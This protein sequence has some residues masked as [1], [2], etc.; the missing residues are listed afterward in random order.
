M[1]VLKTWIINS[2]TENICADLANFHMPEGFVFQENQ[3]FVFIGEF[4]YLLSD[5]RRAIP[6]PST[7]APCKMSAK[8][9]FSY[10]LP[11]KMEAVAPSPNISFYGND[12]YVM[13][14]TH[15]ET[16]FIVEDASGY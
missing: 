1:L 4:E 15:D 14:K 13:T 5:L 3:V 8:G 10:I 9:R 6:V 2:P 7:M 16:I 11:G 12:S